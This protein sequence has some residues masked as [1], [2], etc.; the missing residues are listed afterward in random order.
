M[1]LNPQQQQEGSVWY[2]G[3]GG[4]AGIVAQLQAV[5]VLKYRLVVW[6]IHDER[7]IEGTS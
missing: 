1:D 5:H 2:L 7:A 3:E 6:C 4:K